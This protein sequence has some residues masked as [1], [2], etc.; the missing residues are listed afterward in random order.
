MNINDIDIV[1][2]RSNCYDSYCCI[3]IVKYYYEKYHLDKLKFIKFISCEFNETIKDE[4]INNI[5]AKNTL[6]CNLSL[7]S[8]KISFL[9]KNCKN[10]LF[11][12]HHFYSIKQLVDVNNF[13][14][15]INNKMACSNIIWE[16][17]FPSIEPPIILKYIRDKNIGKLNYPET[18]RF[19]KNI[20]ASGFDDNKW[21]LYLS[22]NFA[23]EFNNS[24]SIDKILLTEKVLIHKINSKESIVYYYNSDSFSKKNMLEISKQKSIADFICFF[25]YDSIT[26]CTFFTIFTINNKINAAIIAEKLGGCGNR[27]C[28]SF[29]LKGNHDTLPF[30]IMDP[31]NLVDLINSG[32]KGKIT[33]NED[34]TYVLFSVAEI[35]ESWL[36]EKYLKLIK[37]HYSDSLLIIFQTETNDI[38]YINNDIVREKNYSIIFNEFSIKKPEKQ[39]QF[40]SYV[41]EN[42]LVFT[43][44]K[45]IDEL[46]SNHIDLCEDDSDGSVED[47]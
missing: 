46:F 32:V 20:F 39:L 11:V 28:A 35:K 38:K 43:S 45:N 19:I 9:M 24:L 13:F 23:F 30:S 41:S 47:E 26:D 14:K 34:I 4:L 3:T 2:Y 40:I 8:D 18:N 33:I 36:G 12:D 15:I 37:K 27:K 29:I 17:F 5:R 10:I 25:D 16:L 7:T 31:N 42:I 44:E 21:K 1:L 6:V 22:N